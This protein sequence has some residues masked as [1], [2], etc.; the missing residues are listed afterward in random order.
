MTLDISR[1]LSGHEAPAE[2]T[3]LPVTI[4]P[5]PEGAD[6]TARLLSIATFNGLCRILAALGDRGLLCADELRGI[7]DAVTTPFDDPKLR[8]DPLIAAFRDTIT[9]VAARSLAR[10]PI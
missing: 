2:P 9:E 8:D 4:E 3:L 1:W 6:D 5:S 10:L 7:E